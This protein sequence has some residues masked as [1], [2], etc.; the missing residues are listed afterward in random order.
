MRWILLRSV[1]KLSENIRNSV[2]EELSR[3][4]ILL[5]VGRT[6]FAALPELRSQS[7]DVVNDRVFYD[8]SFSERCSGNVRP[9]SGL[10]I[11]IQDCS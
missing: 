11:L 5:R 1:L 3:N 4:K 2:L 9:G 6:E 10:R 7:T 8:E